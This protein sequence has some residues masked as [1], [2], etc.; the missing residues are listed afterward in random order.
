M[1]NEDY[2][3]NFDDFLNNVEEGQP[4]FFWYGAREPHRRYE[5]GS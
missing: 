2:A 1:S 4:W 3:A 5:Y